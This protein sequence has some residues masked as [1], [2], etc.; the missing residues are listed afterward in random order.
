MNEEQK[1]EPAKKPKPQ[2]PKPGGRDDPDYE[3]RHGI[4]QKT[5]RK[6]E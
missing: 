3:M 4:W 5:R 6:K 2:P 1:K